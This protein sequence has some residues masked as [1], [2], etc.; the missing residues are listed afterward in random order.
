[1]KTSMM[2]NALSRNA[3]VAYRTA[4]KSP[5]E[6]PRIVFG[7]QCQTASTSSTSNHESW[8]ALKRAQDEA[9]DVTTLDRLLDIV[10]ELCLDVL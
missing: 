2:L 7:R 4:R 9:D 6:R 8:L 10:R 5:L 1:M 3:L